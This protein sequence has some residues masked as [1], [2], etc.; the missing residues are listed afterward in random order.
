MGS[1]KGRE[2]SRGGARRAAREKDAYPTFLTT[3]A[4]RFFPPYQAFISR[5]RLESF[6]LVADSC[7]VSANAGRLFRALFEVFFVFVFFGRGRP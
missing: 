3:F 7:Y 4:L 5:A 1:N 6:S 2:G